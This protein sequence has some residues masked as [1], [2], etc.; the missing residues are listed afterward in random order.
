MSGFLELAWRWKLE[1]RKEV[2]GRKKIERLTQC[3]HVPHRLRRGQSE[4]W[5][6]VGWPAESSSI[7]V[8]NDSSLN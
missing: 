1:R 8:T 7:Q 6:D 5:A 2:G 4:E 3:G